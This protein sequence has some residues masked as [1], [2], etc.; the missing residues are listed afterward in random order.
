ME[1]ERDKSRKKL[2]LLLL[3]L[4]TLFL[5]ASCKGGG[6]SGEWRIPED[7]S[8]PEDAVRMLDEA[9]KG[10]IGTEFEPVA[11]LGMRSSLGTDYCLLCEATVSDPMVSARPYYAAVTVGKKLFGQICTVYP[12]SIGEIFE[13]GRVEASIADREQ[14]LG[15]WF[16]DRGAEIGIEGGLLHLSR[17]AGMVQRHCVLC[18]GN[19]LVFVSEDPQDGMKIEK[20]VQLDVAVLSQSQ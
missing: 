12:L 3:I 16:A 19:R 11:V 6:N 5:F 8:V 7:I 18:T 4:C 20:T 2:A 17:Q 10:I 15:G 13:S 14:M 9:A 1:N